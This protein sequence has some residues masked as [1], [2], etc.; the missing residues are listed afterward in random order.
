MDA[1]Y[2]HPNVAPFISR[3]LIQ[4]FVTGQP[5]PQYVRDVADTFL[6]S[7]G[8]LKQVLRAILLHPEARAGDDSAAP[9]SFDG[10][11]REPVL[12]IAGLLRALGASVDESNGLAAAANTLS[13]NIFF[14]PTVFSYFAPSY[15]IPETTLNAPEFQLD[16]GSLAMAR[17]DF[18]NRLLYG[19]IPGV[20]VNLD[21]F[22]A[23]A[24][25][26]NSLLNRLN[27]LFLHGSMGTQMRDAVSTAMTA[28]PSAKSRAQA[29][30]Y[31][32]GSSQQYQ[33]T[34]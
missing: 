17:A 6:A 27:A 29:A 3:Q 31:L 13:Q 34:R 4:H 30:L 32:V 2:H 14:P 9:A 25:T 16:S 11:F 5:S 1:I 22:T 28:Q 12:F 21:P 20:S 18:V 19:K 8:D 15:L 24:A 23:L 7:N 10:Q 26:P 33:V